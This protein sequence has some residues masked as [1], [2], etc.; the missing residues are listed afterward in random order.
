MAGVDGMLLKF[1]LG[2]LELLEVVTPQ[3]CTALR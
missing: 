3:P 2:G 1:G